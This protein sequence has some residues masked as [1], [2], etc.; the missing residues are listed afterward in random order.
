MAYLFLAQMGYQILRQA[1]E[2][3]SAGVC[4]KSLRNGEGR[5]SRI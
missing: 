4:E 1:R 3:S 2:V 5:R